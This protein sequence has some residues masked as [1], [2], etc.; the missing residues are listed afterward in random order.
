MPD[1]QS[2]QGSE[3]QDNLAFCEST[4]RV[5]GCASSDVDAVQVHLIPKAL[6]MR[7]WGSPIFPIYPLGQ[8]CMLHSTPKVIWLVRTK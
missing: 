4:S 7:P 8:A 5:Q 1:I 3:P 2:A 6:D